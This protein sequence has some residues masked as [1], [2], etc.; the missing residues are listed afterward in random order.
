[1]HKE[2]VDLMRE[3]RESLSGK[4]LLAIGVYLVL[5]LILGT[6]YQ[7][8]Y[9]GG[10]LILVLSG[11]LTLG[12][13]I[14]ALN[15]ARNKDARFEQ[16]FDGFG[17]FGNAVATYLLMVLFI[18]LWSLLLII[19][20]II[21][22]IGYSQSIYILSENPDM[23]PMDVLKKSKDMM[24]GYKAKYFRLCLRFIPWI[25]L[26]ILTLGIGFLWLIPYIYVTFANFYD[27]IK[28]KP[29]PKIL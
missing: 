3:A 21:A 11:P 6:P 5:N 24:Y 12:A 28:E 13:C 27:D 15:I 17:N 18:F 7:S 19:P 29:I 1:M 10:G 8:H 23:D 14:F 26:S 16:L 4:W 25:F 9:I 20:G 2:N 22:A